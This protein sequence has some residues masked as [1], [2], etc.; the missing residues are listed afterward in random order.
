MDKV[1]TIVNYRTT[2]ML[3]ASEIVFQ[4]ADGNENPCID[5]YERNFDS[6]TLEIWTGPG[7]TGI[8]L[9]S[10]DIQLVPRND[11]V[12]GKTGLEIYSGF[13]ITN[14]AY[15]AINLYIPINTLDTYG[16]NLDKTD[17]N[18]LQEQLDAGIPVTYDLTSGNATVNFP[19][20]A[21]S[22]QA[23]FFIWENGGTYK[24]TCATTG[25]VLI[26][27]LSAGK[28]QGEGEGRMKAVFNGTGWDVEVYEDYIA[29]ADS[30]SGSASYSDR[31]YTKYLDGRSELLLTYDDTLDLT[32]ASGGF[33]SAASVQTVPYGIN[34]YSASHAVGV[35]TR[36]TAAIT[37][38]SS[39]GTSSIDIG[40]N[41]GTSAAGVAVGAMYNIVGR[42][43]A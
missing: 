8:K 14:A 9:P 31:F 5:F 16:D 13:R 10:G 3:N 11:F 30:S 24:L 12:S 21:V 33:F 2:P 40:F 20:D 6:A 4:V 19:S 41:R 22:G 26:D 34:F 25:G 17:I 36:A 28:W 39:V 27:G 38:V 32:N 1:K 37:R 15:H 23:I 29:I 42:W 7:S 35:S 18:R 43:R